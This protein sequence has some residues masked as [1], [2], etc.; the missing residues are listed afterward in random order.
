MKLDTPKLSIFLDKR[1]AKKDG[2]FPVKLRIT[3]KREAKYYPTEFNMTEDEFIRQR[4]S[5]TLRANKI[6]GTK[7]Y[8]QLA[9][10]NSLLNNYLADAQKVIDNLKVF[11][12]DT[13]EQKKD[14]H[15]V[16]SDNAFEAFQQK[17]ELLEKEGR[18][19]TAITYRNALKSLQVFHRMKVL[20][21]NSI[22]VKFLEKYENWM[23]EK[24]NSVTT[25]GF[26]L[27]NL[28][29]IINE[30][31][32]SDRTKLEE[33][34][35]GPKK[36]VIPTKKNSKKALSNQDLKKIINYKPEPNSPEAKY[37]DYWLFMYLGNGMNPIDMANLKYANIEKDRIVFRREKTKR[38]NRETT[39][40]IVFLHEQNQK[41]INQWGNPNKP[42]NY[43]FPILQD[44]MTP[45][46]VKKAVSQFGKQINK[47]IGR[48]GE[49]LEIDKHITTYVA[50]HSFV[51]KFLAEGGSL[52]DAKEMTGHTSITTT[53]GYVGSIED[54][55]IKKITN[56][57]SQFS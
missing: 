43:I 7:E 51:T 1:Y 52:L 49:K 24:G 37:L 25:I 45:L 16:E 14:E 17:I 36:Y 5:D 12:F 31:I 42:N 54:D 18:I 8:A 41:I 53:E 46:E 34:P 39:E 44:K 48:I 19:G 33:Y 27:R 26:Y 6:I 23:L 55:R 30:L 50:R 15:I 57:L 40:I 28:R 13:Y 3:Y 10:I 21:L 35:F 4:D 38:T 47:Y 29:A 32:D 20:S 11:N 56:R 9:K 2:K 22:S